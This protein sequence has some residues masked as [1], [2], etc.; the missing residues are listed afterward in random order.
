MT[1]SR[2]RFMRWATAISAL[3]AGEMSPARL[4]GVLNAA[5]TGFRPNLLPTR[6]DILL[7]VLGT[8]V[9]VGR[10]R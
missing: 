6:K 5:E 7:P 10:D 4:I 3:A 1:V 9:A 8:D 2:R